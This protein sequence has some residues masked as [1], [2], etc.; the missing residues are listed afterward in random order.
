MAGRSTACCGILSSRTLRSSYEIPENSLAAIENGIDQGLLLHEIDARLGPGGPNKTFLVHNE[1]AIRVTSKKQRWNKLKLE[2]F[3]DTPLVTRR[4]DLQKNDYAS[5]F[6]N[7][8]DNVADL[9]KLLEGL[10]SGHQWGCTFQIDLRNAD[11]AIAIAW[12]PNRERQPTTLMLKGH[13]NL[14]PYLQTLTTAVKTWARV[15]YKTMFEWGDL[16]KAKLPIIVVF[17]AELILKL[18]LQ[19]EGLDPTENEPWIKIST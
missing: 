8:G 13:N 3:W 9:E 17:Y 15:R 7:T 16:A 1:V 4:F 10:S 11:L 14:S 12:Y 19:A 18:A 5:S 2:E 6:S